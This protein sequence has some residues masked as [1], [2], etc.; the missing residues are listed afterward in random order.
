[1]TDDGQKVRLGKGYVEDI[2]QSGD[3]F[4]S[5]EPK[6]MTELADIFINSPR[7]AM[8][9]AFYKKDKKKPVKQYK[10]EINEVVDKFKNAKVSEIEDIVVNLINNP[11]KETIP[12]ELR[13]MRGR[14]YRQINDLGRV[15]FVD[16]EVEKKEGTYDARLKQVD[17]RTIQ[18]IIV[19]GIKYSL[20]K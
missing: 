5:E 9:V 10:A 18:Y 3:I 19:N 8:T 12:G 13:V 7:V 16:M 1:M 20:K 15:Q 6:N 14:H 4:E 17:P 2:M 11:F